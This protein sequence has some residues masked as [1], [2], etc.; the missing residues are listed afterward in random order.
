MYHG[1]REVGGYRGRKTASEVLR[2]IAAILLVLVIVVLTALWLGGDKLAAWQEQQAQKRQEAASSQMEGSAQSDA[3]A[4]QSAPAVPDAS[5]T[6]EPEPQPEPEPEPAPAPAPAQGMK[7]VE[8]PVSALV[9]GTAAQTLTDRGADAVVVTMKDREG[10]L[11]RQ[12]QQP[13]A[14]KAGVNSANAEINQKLTEWNAGETW[15]VARV[16]CFRDNTVPYQ[17]N[18]VALRASYGNWRD[19][20][21]L[22]W[23]DPLSP[24]A[25]SYIVGLVTELAQMGFDE[26]LLEDCALPIA[27]N[28]GVIRWSSADP[29]VIP[30]FLEQARAA[31]EAGGAKLSIRTTLPVAAGQVSGGGLT[32]QVLNQSAA[33]IWLPAGE[34]DILA[35]ITA[36]GVE[37]PQQRVVEL[38]PALEGESPL[39]RAVLAG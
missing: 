11:S 23:L 20:T 22:R 19:E 30:A 16:V 25:Q 1:R 14:A 39:H 2:W 31:A 12:S 7:A 9:D 18:S 24:D 5:V 37:N 29:N 28:L 32:P 34:G 13:L 33:R 4:D 15:T 26:I 10:R 27:G 3:S 35:E 6:P 36:A 17:Q 21:K 8:L 38:T